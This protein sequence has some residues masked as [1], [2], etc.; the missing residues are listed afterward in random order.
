[1]NSI[2]AV[3]ALLVAGAAY[4]FYEYIENFTPNGPVDPN[5]HWLQPLSWPD[6]FI[7]DHGISYN[8]AASIY[9]TYVSTDP[10][11]FNNWLATT[12]TSIFYYWKQQYPKQVVWPYPAFYP[13]IINYYK[14]K[15]NGFTNKQS[16]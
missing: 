9:E 7:Q 16:Y 5:N 1:M 13:A 4:Y 11:G 2:Y 12:E 8:Q 14:N 15:G 3:G 6:Q 10:S